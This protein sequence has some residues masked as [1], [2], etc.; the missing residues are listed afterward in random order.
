MV[1]E[2]MKW[3]NLFQ[4]RGQDR[5]QCSK[6]SSDFIKVWENSRKTDSWRHLV[7]WSFRM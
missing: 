6:E 2:V 3:I 5:D 7:V 1:Y 4:D